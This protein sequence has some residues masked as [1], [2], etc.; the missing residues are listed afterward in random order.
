ML[1]V[2]NSDVR[3]RTRYYSMPVS[4]CTFTCH[5]DQNSQDARAV[6]L[7]RPDSSARARKRRAKAV[8]LLL[9][10]STAGIGGAVRAP[11]CTTLGHRRRLRAAVLRMK[12]HL[13][14][15]HEVDGLDDVDLAAD[16]PV[17]A[18]RPE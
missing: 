11:C 17:L 12:R 4:N 15:G 7:C 9:R 13:I 8:R 3:S 2:Q 1:E 14:V 18:F 6:N 5:V 16:G 10:N